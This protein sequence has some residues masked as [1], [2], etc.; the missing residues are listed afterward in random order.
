MKTRREFILTACK[1]CA[2]LGTAGLMSVALEG[3][4]S[5]KVVKAAS[6]EQN[7]L[8]VP[9]FEFFDATQVL[10]RSR[11]TDFDILVIKKGEASFTALLMKCTHESQPLTASGSSIYCASHGSKFDLDGKVVLSPA[12]R[13][14]QSYPTRVV[15]ENVIVSLAKA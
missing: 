11:K 13:N 12:T 9:L 3:C 1:A 15:G 4:K 6:N 2:L 10:V 8:L 7:E 14:L 5:L